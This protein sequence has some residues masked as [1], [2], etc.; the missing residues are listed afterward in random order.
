[1]LGVLRA[2]DDVVTRAFTDLAE[3]V[4]RWWPVKSVITVCWTEP[5]KMAYCVLISQRTKGM[6]IK[7]HLPGRVQR[8]QI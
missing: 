6:L 2:H 8:L 4:G 3:I 7:G 5:D 1:M